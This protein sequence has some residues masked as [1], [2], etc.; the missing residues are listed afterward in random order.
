MHRLPHVRPRQLRTEARRLTSVRSFDRDL[1]TERGLV[2]RLLGGIA[3]LPDKTLNA[4]YG[5]KQLYF[6][7]PENSRAL[8]VIVDK[9]E[10]CHTLDLGPCLTRMPYT[11]DP[12]DLRLTKLQ[13]FELNEKDVADCLH[14]LVTL[15]LAESDQPGTM[16]LRV[17]SALVGDDWGW[18]RT[19]TQNIEKLRVHSAVSARGR[20]DAAKQLDALAQA[21][22]EAPKTRRW[23]LRAR[24]GE[25]VR[26]YELP[27]ETAH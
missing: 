17:F 7:D 3:V 18:W 15:P 8:D 1:A 16:D 19:T 27:E 14:L 25:R 21:A 2:L 5:N 4:L 12:L 6:T 23:K 11:L 9:L 24:V 13:I 10:M 22:D 26:W 20:Y